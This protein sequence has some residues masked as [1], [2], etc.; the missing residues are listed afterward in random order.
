MPRSSNKPADA[1]RWLWAVLALALATALA[2]GCAPRPDQEAQAGGLTVG[3]RTDPSPAELGKDGFLFWVKRDGEAVPNAQVA[4]RMFMPGMPMSTDDVWIEAPPKGKGR[5]AAGGEFSMGG[6][7]RVEVR[8]TEGTRAT[9]VAFPYEI[10]WE[11]A[12]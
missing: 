2:P 11:L 6:T 9:R 5:Y 4:F 1:T 3:V 12:R 7:W 8:V 10:K